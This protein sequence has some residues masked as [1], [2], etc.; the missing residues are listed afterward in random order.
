MTQELLSENHLSLV[1][2][3]LQRTRTHVQAY[4][5]GMAS[6]AAHQ[7]ELEPTVFLFDGAMGQPGISACAKFC[8]QWVETERAK[9]ATRTRKAGS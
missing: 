9:A 5:L 6:A 7:A 8:R 2:E 4:Q 1:N 3:C